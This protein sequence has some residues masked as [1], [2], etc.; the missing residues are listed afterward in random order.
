[1]GNPEATR[2]INS[3]MDDALNRVFDQID[4]YQRG[5]YCTED[6]V[7]EVLQTGWDDAVTDAWREYIGED[8]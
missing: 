1:M 4:R 2:W 7:T 8:Q 5:G 3:R 6:E